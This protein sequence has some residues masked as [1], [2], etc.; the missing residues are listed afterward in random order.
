VGEI[1]TPTH[2]SLEA[3]R[4]AILQSVGRDK[5]SFRADVLTG[6]VFGDE[7]HALERLDA[8]TQLLGEAETDSEWCRATLSRPLSSSGA[9]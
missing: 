2:G 9:S 1:D 7:W 3:E 4:R 8:I 6:L 5:A